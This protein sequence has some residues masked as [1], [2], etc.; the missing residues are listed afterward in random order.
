MSIVRGP[1]LK[2]SPSHVRGRETEER[3]KYS[4]TSK[5][6]GGYHQTP[7]RRCSETRPSHDHPSSHSIARGCH[8]NSQAMH[9]P[10]SPACRARR[11]KWGKKQR[12]KN[13]NA[14]SALTG[15]GPHRCPLRDEKEN[16]K[17][18]RR[19]SSF[20]RIDAVIVVNAA[21]MDAHRHAGSSGPLPV[22]ILAPKSLTR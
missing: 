6:N 3:R 16:S 21:A 2:K 9:I 19:S 7:E 1:S 18:V 13:R 14:L 17:H 15:W 5:P 11:G 10:A 22:S 4:N 8:A 12:K 20:P